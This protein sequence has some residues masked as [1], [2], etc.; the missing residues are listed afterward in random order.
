MVKLENFPHLSYDLSLCKLNVWRLV[1]SLALTREY[2]LLSAC[3]TAVSVRMQ[4]A[5]CMQQQQ[6]RI[7]RSAP[8]VGIMMSVVSSA[9]RTHVQTRVTPPPHSRATCHT[10]VSRVPA[11]TTLSNQL[12]LSPSSSVNIWRHPGTSRQP[13]QAGQYLDIY[14]EMKKCWRAVSWCPD[15]SRVWVTL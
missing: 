2:R 15:M 14:Q 8:A 1:S 7:L 11:I 12:K 10:H 5:D 4:P 13:H 6:C 9:V 3:S